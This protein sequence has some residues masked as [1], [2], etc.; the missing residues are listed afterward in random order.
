MRLLMVAGVAVLAAACSQPAE[1]AEHMSAGCEARA[2][3]PW[4]G[5]G[6]TYSVE[7]TTTGPDCERAVATLVIRDSSG[8]PVY[9]EAH[10]AEDIMMLAPARDTAAMQT[11]LQEWV[12][13]DNHTMATTSA[14]PDW[15][16]GATGPQSGEFPFY[17]EEAYD[18]DSYM[19]LRENNL[20]LLCYV[21]GMESQACLAL[22]D[23]EFS[24]VGVQTFPG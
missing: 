22:A 24:K 14:L 7:A 19:R 1:E 18:R 23:G 17:P 9:S 8:T 3:Q 5:A 12:T 11:A 15:P 13:F 20:P 10:M 21:Q 6:A 2:A 16:N 4:Q